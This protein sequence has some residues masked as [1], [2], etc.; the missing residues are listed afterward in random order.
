VPIAHHDVQSSD[1]TESANPPRRKRR[2][3]STQSPLCGRF[4][5]SG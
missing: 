2:L 4:A 5:T 1:R 3:F